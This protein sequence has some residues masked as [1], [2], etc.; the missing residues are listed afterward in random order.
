MWQVQLGVTS[1]CD[2]P[3][4]RWIPG[5]E[6]I[7]TD[8]KIELQWVWHF[9][10]NPWLKRL[11]EPHSLVM[12]H[13][14]KT[15]PHRVPFSSRCIRAQGETREH[16]GLHRNRSKCFPIIR[17]GR[18]KYVCFCYPTFFCLHKIKFIIEQSPQSVDYMW[19]AHINDHSVFSAAWGQT[20]ES[21]SPIAPYRQT[22]VWVSH[23]LY[24]LSVSFT[25]KLPYDS[26]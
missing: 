19:A 25:Q 15:Q 12:Q 9:N 18:A 20:H 10:N 16:E 26:F 7:I 4:S 1:S 3:K 14:V 11:D 21:P 2:F 17:L 22:G 8:G 6:N 23:W 13:R 5:G 24:W